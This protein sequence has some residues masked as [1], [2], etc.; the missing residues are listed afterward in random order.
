MVEFKDLN[1]WNRAMDFAVRVNEISE[2]FPK[3]ELYALVSQMRNAAI[4]VFSNIAEG[5]R[6]GTG[7]ELVYFLHNARGSN[8]E[9]EAQLI[10]AGKVGYIGEV[11]LKSLIDECVEIGKMIT[12]YIK[13]LKKRMIA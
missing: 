11:E 10:Y 2:E 5:C 9:V 6:R 13:F 3:S 7:K 1:V 12:G 8:G 4:S